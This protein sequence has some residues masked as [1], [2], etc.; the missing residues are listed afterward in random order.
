MKTKKEL[1]YPIKYAIMQI[2][3]QVGWHIGLNQLE[4]ENGVVANIVSKCYVISEKK[5]FLSDGSCKVLY[6]VV[7]P[8]AKGG[9][10]IKVDSGDS[11][12]EFNIYSQCINSI[13]VDQL[14]DSFEDA[15]VVADKLN[16][17]ILHHEIGCLPFNEDFKINVEAL[18]IKH[19]EII[20]RCKSFENYVKKETIDMKVTKKY[21]SNLEDIIEKIVESPSEFYTKLAY[22]LSIEEREYLKRAIDKKCC[23]NCT[24]GSC[25]VERFEKVELDES[26]KPQGNNCLSWN[27]PELI[28]KQKVFNKKC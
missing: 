26:R 23:N 15:S 28:G 3:E 21:S 16:E 8:Y 1:K 18:K 14:F 17:D 2:E 19:Q 6:E 5:S 22:A 27:N 11:I 7:F 9:I 25:N 4:R 20:D 13:S 10:G 24:N 12:P